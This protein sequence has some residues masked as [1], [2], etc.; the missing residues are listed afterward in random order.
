MTQVIVAGSRSIE[1]CDRL[2]DAWM[3]YGP[4]AENGVTILSGD[5]SGVDECAE[6]LASIYDHD[7]VEYE[8]EWEKHGDAAG[9]IR[10][11]Q[12]AEDGD[13]LIAVWD[14]ESQGTKNMIGQAVEKGLEIAVHVVD[15]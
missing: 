14:G 2:K 8:A 12:M 9:P 15:G 4:K 6:D 11:E 13:M 7:Y 5:A 10:N 1:N 3:L